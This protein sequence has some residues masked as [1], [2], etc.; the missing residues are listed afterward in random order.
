M[1]GGRSGKIQRKSR[2]SDTDKHAPPKYYLYELVCFFF[3]HKQLKFLN[4]HLR[5][6]LAQEAARLIVEHGIRDYGQAKRK[7][8]E[9]FRVG[10]ASVLPSNAEIESRVLEHQRLF[11]P[12]LQE[13]RLRTLRLIAADIMGMLSSFNPRLTGSVLRGTAAI[14]SGIE[15]HLFS[16]TPENVATALKKN[17]LVFRDYSHRYRFKGLQWTLVSGFKFQINGEEICT[18]VFSEMGIRQAPLSPVDQRPMKRVGREQLLALL[19]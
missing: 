3:V 17:G 6:S 1:L 9:Q 2:S 18:L 14:N 15:L 5:K 4:E 13:K 12:E 11:E 10:G 8:A 19:E 16:D 7:A